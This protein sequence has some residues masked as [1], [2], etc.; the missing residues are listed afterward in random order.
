MPKI[1]LR[2][3]NTTIPFDLHKDHLD[4]LEIP[5]EQ[6]VLTDIEIGERLDKPRGTKP[7]E[8]LVGEKET[9]LFVVPDATR[10]AG[11]GQIINLLVRR[12]IASGVEPHQMAAIFAIGIHRQV[13]E[14]EKGAILTPFIAQRIKTLDHGPRDL[15]KLVNSGQ[16]SGGIP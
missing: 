7:L 5:Y 3:G 8:D 11:V 4:V 13:T 2:Y 14:D 16:T 15:V 9:V 1:E 6:E 12:L 10:N